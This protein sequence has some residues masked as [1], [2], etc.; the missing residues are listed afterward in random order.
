[1]QTYSSTY[2]GQQVFSVPGFFDNFVFT[3]FIPVIIYFVGLS[4]RKLFVN[5]YPFSYMSAPE[6]DSSSSSETPVATTR[7]RVW[8]III[9]GFV[10]LVII[11]SL[12]SN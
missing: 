10:G 9:I 12:I 1:M 8:Q 11:G 3:A 7:V 4:V 6:A 5:K 2:N